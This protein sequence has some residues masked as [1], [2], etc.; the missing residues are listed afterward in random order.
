MTKRKLSVLTLLFSTIYI[1]PP[2]A[3]A[4]CPVCTL[5]VG[6]GLGLSRYLGIDDAVSGIWAGALV[7]SFSLW[8]SNWLTKKGYKLLKNINQ[9]YLPYLSVILWT[10][11]T[12]LPLWKMEV[13]GHPFNTIWGIDKLLF[14]SAVGAGV[15]LTAQYTDKKLRKIKG[16]QLISFQKVIIPVIFLISASLLMFFYGGYLK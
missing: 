2:V 3:F 10:I 6:A 13:I 9:K 5:A 1:L 12:Y 16:K 8:F 15:L 11:L 7:I 14:G 4:Q